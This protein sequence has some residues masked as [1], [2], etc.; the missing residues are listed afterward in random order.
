[1]LEPKSSMNDYTWDE[2]SQ[3]AGEISA[4]A[5]EGDAL[6]LAAHFHVCN[7][8]GSLDG[9]QVKAFTLADGTPVEAQVVGIYHDE[10][11]EGTGKAGISFLAKNCVAQR[12]LNVERVNAGGWEACA[13]R[14]FLNGEFLDQLPN[15]LA[16]RI[17]PVVKRTNNTGK[18]RTG[19]VVGATVDRVWLPSLVEL[20][21]EPEI[22]AHF[23]RGNDYLA[24]VWLP[25]GVQYQLFRSQGVRVDESNPILVK[26]FANEP[27]FWY[28]RSPFPSYGGIFVGVYIDGY[29]NDTGEPNLAE[30]IAPGFCL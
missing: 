26:T 4:C 11:A 3:I 15:D 2:L 24:Q 27:S 5:D 18:A 25:E 21:G 28:T 9:T 12:P 13:A 17:V 22:A 1:M 7:E 29:P 16:K 6:A 20:A 19:D 30:G 14:A 10:L 23:T 8:D